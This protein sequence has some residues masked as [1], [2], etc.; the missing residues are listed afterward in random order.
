MRDTSSLGAIDEG[1][2]LVGESVSSVPVEVGVPAAPYHCGGEPPRDDENTEYS[3][4]PVVEDRREFLR[5]LNA[6]YQQL[7]R[8]KRSSGTVRVL[9]LVDTLGGVPEVRVIDSSGVSVLNSAAVRALSSIRFRPAYRDDQTIC[10]WIAFP[11]VFPPPSATSPGGI[12]NPS[13]GG[14]S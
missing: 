8:R 10:M 13:K 7:D 2:S 9:F 6:A 12:V 14:E 4:P 11:I 1:S 5:V 3:S